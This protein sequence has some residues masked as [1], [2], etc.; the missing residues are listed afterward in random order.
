MPGMSSLWVHWAPPNER[1]RLIGMSHAGGMIGN[2]FALLIGGILCSSFAGWPS[3]F[4]LFGNFFKLKIKK[5]V[6]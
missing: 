6:K 2:I 1:S 5:K 4:Y 3:I